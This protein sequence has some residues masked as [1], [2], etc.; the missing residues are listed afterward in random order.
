MNHSASFW[1]LV[2]KIEP[3][4]RRLDRELLAVWRIVPAWVFKV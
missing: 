4:Y 2:G 3:D 1:T